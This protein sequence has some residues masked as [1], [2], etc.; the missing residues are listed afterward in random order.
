MKVLVI[1]TGNWGLDTSLKIN[2]DILNSYMTESN[3]TVEYAAI[4]CYDDFHNYEDIIKFKYKEICNQKILTR[5]S[6]F[7]NKHKDILD[8]DWY[9]RFR[10]EVKLFQNID[11]DNL[12]NNSI[13]AR[14]R[15]YI[16]PRKLKYGL[17]VVGNG[18]WSNVNE[19]FYKENEENIIL[20]DIL[21][22][23]HKNIIKKNSFDYPNKYSNNTGENEWLHDEYYKYKGINKNIISLNMMYINKEGLFAYS[24]NINC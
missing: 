16:G 9:I 5:L 23:F 17:A 21:I 8:Y 10:P 11:F 12:C 24:G 20:D 4:S 2:I 15:V 7:I 18:R 3:N 14:A 1:I 13:N 22:I 19:S 6:Y